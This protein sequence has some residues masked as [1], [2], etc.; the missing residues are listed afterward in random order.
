MYLQEDDIDN[1]AD[2][3]NSTSMEA[4]VALSLPPITSECLR[5]KANSADDQGGTSHRHQHHT[6]YL[7][8]APDMLA[9]N[10]KPVKELVD[11]CCTSP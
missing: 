3:S 10:S 5:V 2:Y 8:V 1:Y 7:Q 9:G 4:L 6:M 11:H